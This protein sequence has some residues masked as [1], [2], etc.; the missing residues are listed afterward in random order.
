MMNRYKSTSVPVRRS[1]D[2]SPEE[3]AGKLVI[4]EL[5][6]VEKPEFTQEMAKL[7]SRVQEAS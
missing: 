6:N 7:I 1:K 5:L 2:M 3:L 4:G